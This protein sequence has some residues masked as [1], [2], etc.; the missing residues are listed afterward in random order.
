VVLDPAPALAML[1]DRLYKY[2]DILTPNQT[3]GAALVGFTVTDRASAKQAA[4]VLSKRGPS[5]VLITLGAEGLAGWN[6]GKQMWIERS[7]LPVTAID[8]TAAGDAFNGGLAAALAAGL[9]LDLAIDWAMA[10]GALA[11]TKAG[12]QPSLP[13]RSEVLKHIGSTLD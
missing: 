9:E 6:S 7:A 1:P 2:V 11:V 5:L 13:S 4:Q 12:A 3:E 8:T 10:A